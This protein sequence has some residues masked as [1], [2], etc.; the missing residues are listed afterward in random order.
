MTGPAFALLA[1]VALAA[2]TVFLRR[3]LI[4]GHVYVGVF[5]S[6][7]I[8]I[9]AFSV[10]AY[11]SGEFEYVTKFQLETVLILGA[12]GLIHV[13]GG[14]TFL[15]K[16]IQIIGSNKA[17][18]IVST[19]IVIAIILGTT[20]LSEPLTNKIIIS[21]LILFVGV[22]LVSRG[23]IHSN[24]EKY[25][26]YVKGA[27]F[28]FLTAII[29]SATPLMVRI[30]ILQTGAPIL[31]GLVSYVFAIIIFTSLLFSPNIRTSL[32][33]TDKNSMIY[34]V[35]AAVIVTLGKLFEYLA[36]ELIGV[37]TV[38]P[39]MG[40]ASL[41]VIGFS[42]IFNRR[43][44]NFGPLLILGVILVVLGINASFFLE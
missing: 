42:Y 23:E 35:V 22:I 2:S 32:T 9:P 30:G 24:T 14:R 4:R 17:S 27:I 44:E 16:S 3:G 31:C 19:N 34:F 12:A 37:T 1:A 36:L 21:G 43:I 11:I 8:G 41:F 29:F 26:S 15:Y 5:M 40:S 28:A 10:L 20:I 7:I 38:V 39:L 25:S 6:L 18:P 33:S 13:V